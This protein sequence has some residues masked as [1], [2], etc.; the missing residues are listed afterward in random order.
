SSLS[1]GRAE[2]TGGLLAL[3]LIKPQFLVLV[4]PLALIWAWR[5]GLA[6]KLLAGFMLALLAQAVALTLLWPA[7][8][9]DYY[10][11]LL[12]NP[13]WDQPN[14]LSWLNGFVQPELAWAVW[15]CAAV[16]GILLLSRTSRSSLS[17]SSLWTLALTPVLSPYVWSWDFVLCLPL[18]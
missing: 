2:L 10:T 15:G 5:R 16:L 18:V 7:W 13:L 1:H 6:R 8:L 12:R 11:L 3:L 14:L 9:S 4:L 17:Q